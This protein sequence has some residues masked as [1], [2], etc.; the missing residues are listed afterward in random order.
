MT[1][2]EA[3]LCRL[4]PYLAQ[5]LD[6]LCIELNMTRNEVLSLLVERARIIEVDVKDVGPIRILTPVDRK[7]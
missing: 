2:D 4:T 3:V 6:A 5:R 1:Y 7:S